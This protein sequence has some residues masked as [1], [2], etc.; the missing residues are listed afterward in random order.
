M[1]R[2][3]LRKTVVSEN[4]PPNVWWTMPKLWVQMQSSISATP[5]LPLCRVLRKS[6]LMVPLFAFWNS[7]RIRGCY[8]TGF[9]PNQVSKT[10]GWIIHLAI[11]HPILIIMCLASLLGL[12]VATISDSCSSSSRCSRSIIKFSASKNAPVPR[13]C[14]SESALFTMSRLTALSTPPIRPNAKRS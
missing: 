5:H 3:F 9:S 6:P 2:G 12:H 8:K 1:R 14:G 11:I 10:F 13:C 4:L 7:A